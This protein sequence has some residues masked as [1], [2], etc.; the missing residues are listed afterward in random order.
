MFDKPDDMDPGLSNIRCRICGEWLAIDD[1]GLEE[2]LCNHCLHRAP[3]SW[4]RAPGVDTRR[5]AAEALR[6][7]KE[8]AAQSSGSNDGPECEVKDDRLQGYTD[9]NPVKALL[10][11]PELKSIN[12]H[13]VDRPT[14]GSFQA[15]GRVHWFAH[16][17]SS[18]K[19]LLESER[20]ERWL[21]RYRLTLYADDRTGLLPAEVFSVL[22]VVEG[23]RLTLLELAFD[24]DTEVGTR[25]FV[26]KQTLFGK[27]HRAP[28][29]DETDYV[30][31]RRAGKLVRIYEKE[32]D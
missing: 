10:K 25:K 3:P 9:K 29:V 31:S 14:N 7:L 6:H 8:R 11:V 20:R 15:Y 19:L 21:P 12:G 24:F 13:R 26:E 17:K 22:E 16:R 1:D 27:S 30:G 4:T 2:K 5:H 18:M 32:I 28:S 23:F